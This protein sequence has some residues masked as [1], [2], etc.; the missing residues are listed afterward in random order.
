MCVCVC[1]CVCVLASSGFIFE[2]PG[3]KWRPSIKFHIGN[4]VVPQSIFHI[5]YH[6]MPNI[7]TFHKILKKK[8]KKLIKYLFFS[9]EYI[10]YFFLERIY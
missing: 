3:L 6:I 5:D 10:K 8:K 1:V 2:P 4:N 7:Y 9:E